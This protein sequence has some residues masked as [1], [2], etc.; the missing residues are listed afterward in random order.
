MRVSAV[1]CALLAA[2]GGSKSPGEP[3]PPAPTGLTAT[4]GAG[5]I[6]L[7]WTAV[8]GATSYNVL[9]GDGS[10]TEGP[11]DPPVSTTTTS[12][13]DT[14]VVAGATYFYR[15]QAVKGTAASVASAEASATTIPAAPANLG[16]T[17]TD[18]A[19][20]LNWTAAPG[21]TSYDVLRAPGGTRNFAAV[22]TTANP[23]IV[24]TGLTPNTTYVYEVR[25]GNATGK[26]GF[27][28]VNATTAPTAPT[29]LSVTAIS[30]HHVAL[31]WTAPPSAGSG[32]YRILHSTSSSGPFTPAG[33]STTNLFTDTMLTNNTTWYFVVHTIGGSGE[34]GDSN[35][36]TGTPYIELCALDGAA[37]TIAAYD[38]TANG[39]VAPK[40]SFGWQTG[41]AIG[42]GI[43]TDGT[44][45]YVSSKYTKTVNVY[46]RDLSAGS[47][48]TITIAIPAKATALTLDTTNSELYVAASDGN[49]YVYTIVATPFSATLART[50]TAGTKD[51]SINGL[52]LDLTH[53]QLF[54]VKHNT[55]AVFART[56]TGAAAS[57]NVIQP[58][59]SGITGTTQ[60]YGG[61]YDSFDDTIWVTWD[62]QVG[63]GQAASYARTGNGATASKYTPIS[64]GLPLVHG[65]FLQPTTPTSYIWL[66][67]A[68]TSAVH[69]NEAIF[70]FNRTTGVAVAGIRGSNTGF[71]QPGPMW[72]DSAN[73]E[74]WVVNAHDGVA[75]FTSSITNGTVPNLSP[76]R[77][78]NDASTGLLDPIG[79]AVDHVNGEIVEL[80]YGPSQSL[81]V[82]LTTDDGAGVFPIRTMSGPS[83]TLDAVNPV[84]P[85]IDNANGQYWISES[86]PGIAV[87]DRTLGGTC[88]SGV[89]DG[90]PLQT[91][92]GA[93]LNIS[94]GFWLAY[95]D[96]AKSIVAAG[97]LPSVDQPA[98]LESWPRT[99]SGNTAATAAANL[100]L[101]SLL[102]SPSFD[103]VRDQLLV[104]HGTENVEI[105]PR[106]FASGAIPPVSSFTAASCDPAIGCRAVVDGEGGEVYVWQPTR[107]D[108]YP[109]TSKGTPSPSRT[110]QG[111][112]TGLYN[113]SNVAICN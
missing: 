10:G 23:S 20:T 83:T 37:N 50:L 84:P 103:Y 18:S 107:I 59:T 35:V 111:S 1:V 31:S 17:T 85:V 112:S 93:N 22:G 109:T 108:V 92:Q 41:I 34:S 89:C 14:A 51:E 110:I 69:G 77:S 43:A 76:V 70:K 75:A 5:Q 91:L 11:L 55:I 39:N 97:Y 87:L 94:T 19:A 42:T 54:V 33:T 65:I 71:Y 21:A 98:E 78:L 100:G 63:S 3:P 9:R 74:I 6:A 101:P 29:G 27:A 48:P 106:A 90:A 45:L 68:G 81:N 40:R 53:G 58:S 15:V 80:D 38:G 62:A 67:A 4:G 13:V 95:D 66:A 16:V 36:V 57:A 86:Q 44:N 102:V 7:S 99:A 88:T 105:Y 25:A 26:S 12:Y 82:Y 32:G 72:F 52:G 8:T 61:V 30:N 47:A 73:S 28:T 24:D 56:A 104:V 49:V 96:V 64:A 60:L 46:P 113:V 2:C 79:I